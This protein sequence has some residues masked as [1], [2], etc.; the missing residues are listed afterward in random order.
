LIGS[1]VLKE[2]SIMFIYN[3]FTSSGAEISA[4]DVRCA[5]KTEDACENNS[6][7]VGTGFRD[8]QAYPSETCPIDIAMTE[9]A[10]IE[11]RNTEAKLDMGCHPGSVVGANESRAMHCRAYRA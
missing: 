5:T 2:P 10:Q 7:S 3:F 4:T 9:V 11:R 8:E 6:S 1:I